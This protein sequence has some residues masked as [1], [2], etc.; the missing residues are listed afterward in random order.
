MDS[1]LPVD[2]AAPVVVVAV[3]LPEDVAA[4][5]VVAAVESPV[6]GVVLRSL[7]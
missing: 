6:P 7:L 1:V 3:V 5:V 4:P 2:V